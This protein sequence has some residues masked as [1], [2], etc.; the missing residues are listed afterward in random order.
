MDENGDLADKHRSSL[1]LFKAPFL[2]TDYIGVLIGD[3]GDVAAQSAQVR[4][5]LSM[6][7]D[8]KGIA[9]HLRRNSVLPS[10]RFVPPMMPG[11]CSYTPPVYDPELAEKLLSNLKGTKLTISTTADYVDLC[12]AIQFSWGNLGLN[13]E[14]DVA[15][16][17]VQRE[18]VATSQ[19]ELF[20][21]SWLA[22]Y[23]DAENFLGLFREANFSPGGPNYT[24]YSNEEF[25]ALY[26]SA[27]VE[28]SDSLRWK[29]YSKMDS[30]IHND[31]PVIP[32]FHDQVTHFVSNEV[33][34]WKVSPV[35]RLDL[36]RVKLSCANAQN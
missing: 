14:I 33:S 7:V 4:R 11:A 10:D 2:K 13:V 29:L 23:A 28:T 22:D 30:I 8:R 9:K 25:E 1:N 17:S 16:S 21:K 19:A 24:H 15:P 31:M 34:G 20:K 5:A 26:D 32:L 3:G 35:N 6:S 12:S 27:M 18:K 36:R